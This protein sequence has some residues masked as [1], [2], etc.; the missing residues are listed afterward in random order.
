MQ[1]LLATF[2]LFACRFGDEKP[3]SCLRDKLS[4]DTRQAAIRSN[5]SID[6]QETPPPTDFHIR[7]VSILAPQLLT[8]YKRI[9]DPCNVIM[10]WNR[11]T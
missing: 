8:G 7:D 5:G 11:L 1:I 10:V 9:M 6:Y 4:R 3:A 2:H